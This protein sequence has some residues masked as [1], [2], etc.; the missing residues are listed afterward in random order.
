MPDWQLD[1]RI[2]ASGRSKPETH[3][4]ES[5]AKDLGVG[6]II[7]GEDM[8]DKETPGSW[9]TSGFNMSLE[10]RSLVGGWAGWRFLHGS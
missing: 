8:G 4:T 3:N 5:V 6:N 2:W 1:I 7:Q 10:G 9:E